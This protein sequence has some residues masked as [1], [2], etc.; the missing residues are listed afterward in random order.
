MADKQY[1]KY[2][3][4]VFC[5][6]CGAGY[7]IREEEMPEGRGVKLVGSERH[8]CP[9]CGHTDD[10]GPDDARFARFQKEGLG[11]RKQRP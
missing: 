10:Y 1:G 2:Y 8:T 9:G 3:L 4:V 11:R 6:S 5:K 7:R